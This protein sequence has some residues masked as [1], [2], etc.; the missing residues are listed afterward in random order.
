MT[1]PQ[2][3]GAATAARLAEIG[4][5]S[6]LAPLLAFRHIPA[7]LP[8]PEMIA[9]IALTS[10]NALRSLDLQ[11]QVP[12]Y[13]HLP[14]YAVGERTAAE[15]KA[16]GFDEVA[17]ADG[18]GVGLARLLAASPISGRILYPAARER[19][20]ELDAAVRTEGMSVDTVVVY[21]M[22]PVERLPRSVAEGLAEG[23][24]GAGLFYS[25]RTAA[26]F[27]ELAGGLALSAK[28]CLAVLCM[29]SQVAEPL[30]TAGFRRAGTAARPSE[31]AMIELAA[32]FARGQIEA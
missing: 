19:S 29:S 2:P 14:V 7:A 8:A 10:T 9:A 24:F 27:A 21:A 32:A 6:V 28:D 17:A 26:V 31:A 15:A 4:I 30:V 11:G 1:R 23:S 20:V 12:R 5:P 25:R 16:A 13:A 3:D 22:E 18:T